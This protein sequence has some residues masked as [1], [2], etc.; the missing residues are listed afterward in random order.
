[1]GKSWPVIT[2]KNARRRERFGGI[3]S[4]Y[5]RM[6]MMA[7]QDLRVDHPGQHDVVGKLCLTGALRPRIDFAEWFA[8]YL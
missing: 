6:R 2:A 3:D 7:A 8:H 1:M 5:Q 4:F